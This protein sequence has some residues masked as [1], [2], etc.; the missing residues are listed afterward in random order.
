MRESESFDAFYA[1]TVANV[2][3]QMHALAGGDPQADHAIREAYARAYQQW[4]EVSGY[5]DPEAWVLDVARDAFERRRSQPAEAVPLPDNGTWPGMYRPRAGEAAPGPDPDATMSRE[6]RGPATADAW[7]PDPYAAGP[8]AGNPYAAGPYPGGSYQPAAAQPA[9]APA[10]GAAG[11]GPAGAAAPPTTGLPPS[12]A[13]AGTAPGP[14]WS[15]RTGG[16]R[17]LIAI[18]AVIALLAVGGVAYLAFGRGSTASPGAGTGQKTAAKSGPHMLRAG[19]IGTLTSVPWSLVGT[20][21]TLADYST[22]QPSASGQPS[23]GSTTTFLVDPEGGRYVIYQWPAGSGSTLLAWSGDTEHA[24]FYAPGTGYQLLTL[25]GQ[26]GSGQVVPLTLPPGVVVAGFTR[27]DGTNLLA[28]RQGP[29]L[30][31]LQRYTLAGVFQKTLATMPRRP[32][33]AA[34]PGTCAS[35]ECGALSSPT[36]LMAVWG[37]RGDEMQLVSNLG[38]VLGRLTVPGSGHPPSCT[39]VSWWNATTILADCSAPSPQ[40]QQLRLWLV[41]DQGGTPTPLTAPAGGPPGIGF[42]TGAWQADG[43]VYATSI[44]ASQCPGATASLPGGL[45]LENVTQAGSPTPVTIAGSTNNYS[46]VVSSANGRLIVLAET[47]CPGS[48]SLL[49]F[50]PST[51]ATQTLLAAP[52]SQAGVTAAAPWGLGPTATAGN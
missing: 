35:S 41:P 25:H 42:L 15:S 18:V 24:L 29:A 23:G 4:F 13:G 33:Q 52:T 36:G 40:A 44:S 5:R 19:R 9:S 8:D 46:D 31:K 3:G 34:L 48:W 1:R 17:R 37:L 21:W 20:G 43:G 16:S 32:G 38:G 30:N 11:P 26:P 6:A 47:G 45:E 51:N 7:R 28:V 2:T 22:G 50:D 39:P 14:A 27:P 10:G 49:S 12:G